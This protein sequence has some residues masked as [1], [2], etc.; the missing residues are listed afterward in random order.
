[1][2]RRVVIALVFVLGGFAAGF[3]LTTRVRSAA[4]VRPESPVA[5]APIPAQTAAPAPVTAPPVTITGGFPDFSKVAA[6]AVRGVAN[7]S[8]LQVVRTTNSPFGNDPFFRYFFGDEQGFGS[9][10][11]RSLSLGSGVVITP[12]GLRRHQQPC[13]RGERARDHG[14]PWPTS[15]RSAAWSSGPIRPPTSRC[16]DRRAESAGPG[17]CGL[18]AIEGR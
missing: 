12:D 2:I 8:S 17:L 16:E 15:A 6:L 5:A 13:R 3:A 10:D 1:M 7:I 4:A 14:L 11:R 9:R 18:L